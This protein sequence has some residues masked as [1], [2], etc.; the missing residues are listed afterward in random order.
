M[1][2]VSDSVSGVPIATQMG[3]DNRRFNWPS[4]QPNIAHVPTAGITHTSSSVV[5]NQAFA[6]A[7]GTSAAPAPEPV[8]AVQEPAAPVAAVVP[9]R[10]SQPAQQS[11]GSVVQPAT[12]VQPAPVAAAARNV[13]PAAA[14]PWGEVVTPQASQAGEVQP[15][16]AQPQVNPQALPTPSIAA[17]PALPPTAL[18]PAAEAAAQPSSSAG[19]DKLKQKLHELIES[20]RQAYASDPR[21]TK[22]IQN[23]E[24]RMPAL[25]Q[26]ITEGDVR[27]RFTRHTNA[28]HP[29]L[30]LDDTI[31]GR[32]SDLVD[33]LQQQNGPAASQAYK[34]LAKKDYDTV[35]AKAMLGLKKLC[36]CP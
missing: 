20:Y 25:N 9:E 24:S 12:A 28:T 33:L 36:D 7:F 3:T 23:A 34:E 13:V 21:K 22:L 19:G 8:Q 4:L 2:E 1:I 6:D 32:I 16:P 29:F 10:P 31:I 15:I 35:G 27:H 5:D 30:Q 18:A 26:K 14:T 17:E 11:W